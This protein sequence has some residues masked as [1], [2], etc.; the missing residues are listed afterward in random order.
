MMKCPSVGSGKKNDFLHENKNDTTGCQT[1][2]ATGIVRGR[3]KEPAESAA[4]PNGRIAAFI[5]WG[6]SGIG[7][8]AVG[9]AVRLSAKGFGKFILSPQR[10]WAA[11][12][13]CINA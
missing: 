8:P 7:R 12:R 9:N 5:G 10:N 1:A 3:G 11:I 6:A 4:A 2:A 13:N